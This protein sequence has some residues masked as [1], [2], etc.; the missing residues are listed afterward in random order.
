VR[1]GYRQSKL[2][3]LF[4]CMAAGILVF[5][6]LQVLVD[7]LVERSSPEFRRA[8]LN[9]V[10][11]QHALV[12]GGVE[13]DGLDDASGL[14]TQPAGKAFLAL[15]PLMAAS[16]ERLDDKIRD[17]KLELIT[18]Q[19]QQGFG[20]VAG[21]YGHYVAAV[22]KTQDQWQNYRRIPTAQSIDAEIVRQQDKAWNDYLKDLGQRGWTPSTVPGM[23]RNA[24]LRKVRARVPVSSHWKLNDEAG[25]RDAVAVQVRRKMS[26][27]TSEGSAKAKAQRIPSGLSWP[28]FFAQTSVQTELRKVLKLP[29]SVTLQPLYTSSAEFDRTVFAPMVLEQA[30]RELARYDAKVE[31]FANGESNAQ[32]GLDAARMTIVPPVALFFSLL[33]AVGHLAKLSYLLLKLTLTAL[34]AQRVPPR[35][36]W[37]LPLTILALVWLGLSLANNEIT[38]SRLHAYITQQVLQSGK[39]AVPLVNALHVVAVGQGYAYP[40]NEWV[41]T[42]VLGGITYGYQDAQH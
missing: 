12:K 22:K 5:V 34:P 27:A 36:L 16:V 18:R 2:S 35:R 14:F 40:I 26:A 23:A 19:I 38:R 17:A 33:G 39:G 28:M 31:T 30:R 4:W 20:G 6:L 15:F 1:L 41:R 37:L 29:D 11:V 24:V 32:L 21:Y 3:I 42:R 8:S 13:L 25:F 7:Q 9:I 10:L